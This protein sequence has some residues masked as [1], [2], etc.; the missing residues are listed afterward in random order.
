MKKM[1]I[2]LRDCFVCFLVVTSIILAF[3]YYH[4]RRV[5]NLRSVVTYKELVSRF[6]DDIVS[7]TNLVD[8]DGANVRVVFLL[9]PP[10]CSE[11][12][13][14]VFD[15]EGNVIGRC[16][17]KSMADIKAIY[18]LNRWGGTLL[19]VAVLAGIGGDL[20]SYRCLKASV[21]VLVWRL[22]E[23]GFAAIVGVPVN[24]DSHV[25]RRIGQS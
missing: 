16:S 25:F 21:D 9:S 15:G 10:W 23:E 22:P 13:A 3:V 14:I 1:L 7:E 24:I 20:W 4:S 8:L 19:E 18:S 5:K 6:G 11:C 17:E 2:C 12:L